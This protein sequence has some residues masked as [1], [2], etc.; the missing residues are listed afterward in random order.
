MS[1][2]RGDSPTP[3]SL[4]DALS[5]AAQNS[6]FGKVAPGETPTAGALLG[7]MGGVRGI[8]ESLLPGF[9]FVV[10]YAITQETLPSVLIP[11]AIAVLFVLVR[12]VTRTPVVPAL[13][14]LLGIAVSAALA[15]FSGDAKENFVL[16]FWLNGAYVVG[17]LVSLLARWP[18]IGI[19]VGLLRGEGTAW[20][21]DK[22]KYRIAFVTTVL[23]TCMFAARLAVQVPLYYADQTQLLG[24]AKL[25]MGLPLYAATLWVT[26]LLVRAVYAKGAAAASGPGVH[27]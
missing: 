3:P 10:V 9:V 5:A 13:V 14:G 20:R 2:D 18:V 15:I 6:G 11:A 16:G 12:L 7:A 23:W 4:A 8:V 19:I 25:I 1:H 26:W 21:A 22:A 17:L 24:G 27:G